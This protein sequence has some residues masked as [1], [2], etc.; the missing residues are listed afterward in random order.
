MK[1]TYGMEMAGTGT[2]LNKEDM[3]SSLEER[4]YFNP[5]R[6]EV[7]DVEDGEK[8]EIAGQR[9]IMCKGPELEKKVI[10]LEE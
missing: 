7:L 3:K 4:G 8:R 10:L 5:E 9:A 1:E 2:T 6:W